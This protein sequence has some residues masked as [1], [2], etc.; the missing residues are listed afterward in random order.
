MSYDINN[1]AF[2]GIPVRDV[3]EAMPAGAEINMDTDGVYVLADDKFSELAHN[4][5]AFAKDWE[6]SSVETMVSKG[7]LYA[8][9]RSYTG[10]H[11]FFSRLILTAAGI[12]SPIFYKDE[13]DLLPSLLFKI[14]FLPVGLAPFTA[15]GKPCEH[16]LVYVEDCVLVPLLKAFSAQKKLTVIDPADDWDTPPV[17]LTCVKTALQNLLSAYNPN[18]DNSLRYGSEAWMKTFISKY[19]EAQDCSCFVD[20]GSTAHGDVHDLGGM[21]DGVPYVVYG[22]MCTYDEE[23]WSDPREEDPDTLQQAKDCLLGEG[24]PQEWEKLTPQFGG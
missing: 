1:Y 11:A 9:S 23:G 14:N 22:G 21:E 5:K 16:S 18:A 12:A 17:K 15:N 6:C 24:A 10:P 4:V 20:V 3:A 2:L 7:Y 19:L 13:F 8:G